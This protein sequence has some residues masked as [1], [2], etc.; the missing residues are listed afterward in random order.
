MHTYIRT[1]V[2]TLESNKTK[3]PLRESKIEKFFS[4]YSSFIFVKMI[5]YCEYAIVR[6]GTGYPIILN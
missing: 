5:I 2:R 1:Y 3:L 6:H 4:R